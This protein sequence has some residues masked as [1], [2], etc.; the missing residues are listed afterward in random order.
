MSNRV[1]FPPFMSEPPIYD[2]LFDD[3]GTM[4]NSWVNWFNSITR[5]TGYVIVH[6]YIVKTSPNE[7]NDVPLLT[8]ISYSEA[9][10]DLLQNARNGTIIYNTDTDKINIRENNAWRQITTTAA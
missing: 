1:F 7:R 3:D 6:D 9:D 10:R 4:F 8:A 5:V 2:P